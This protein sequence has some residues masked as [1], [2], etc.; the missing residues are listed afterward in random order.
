MLKQTV[1]KHKK[2]FSGK[3]LFEPIISDEYEGE[4]TLIG[5]I[6]NNAPAKPNKPSGPTKVKEGETK[7]YS[8]STT[9]PDTNAK[10]D[11]L[12]YWRDGTFDLIENLDSG[13]TASASH[14]WDAQANYNIY[15]ISRDEHGVYS[16]WSDPL[17]VSIPKSK[18]YINTP[19][20]NFLQNHPHMFPLL[21]HLLQ[22]FL[23]L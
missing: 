13:V 15:V 9:D 17:S 7:T 14:K 1:L 20:L 22:K 6:T 3:L 4:L 10:L 23:K 11:Y 16:E 21:Q 19:F 18:S 2:V 5:G 8:T 12:F